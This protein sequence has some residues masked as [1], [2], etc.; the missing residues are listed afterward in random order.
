[1]HFVLLLKV[2]FLMIF[3]IRSQ[4]DSG[5]WLSKDHGLVC[6]NSPWHALRVTFEGFVF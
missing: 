4:P 5:T 3:D 1:M 2:L 6:V